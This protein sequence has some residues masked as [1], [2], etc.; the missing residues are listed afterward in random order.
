MPACAAVSEETTI[1]TDT[2][3]TRRASTLWIMLLTLASTA[4]TLVFACATPFPALAAL[5]A[6][7][8]RRADGVALAVAAWVASQAVGFC[9]LDYSTDASTMLWGVAIGTAAVAGA[10]AAHAAAARV[11]AS[12][13]A[14]LA[15][16]YLAA[17][18]AFKLVIL[19][20]SLGRGEVGSALSVEIMARQFARNALILGG[21]TALYHLLVRVGVPTPRR[22]APAALGA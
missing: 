4:T 17:F 22:L 10:V 2:L 11:P 15:A 12:E 5:A 20:W 19:L 14:R 8:M 21:L 3:S 9:L 18:V 1:M 13:P 6:A 16:G 7:H